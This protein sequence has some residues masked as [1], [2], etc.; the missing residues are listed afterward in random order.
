MYTHT[1]AAKLASLIMYAYDMNEKY[2]NN[3]T[4]PADP[5]IKEDGWNLIAYISGDDTSFSVEKKMLFTLPQSICYGYIAEKKNAPGEYVIIFRGTD[6]TNL[7]EDLHNIIAIF[8]SPWSSAP[9]R[10]VSRGF[11][12]VYDSLKLIAFNSEC[13][14]SQL[15]LANAITQIIGINGQFTILAHSL[16]AAI[17]SYLMCDIAFLAPN[18]S[19]CLFACPRPGNNE[20]VEY[21]DNNFS[22]Y[23]VFNY[24][25]DIVPNLPPDLPVLNISQQWDYEYKSLPNIT[26]LNPP[27][28][29]NIADSIGCNHYL[30]SYIA[31]LDPDEF[32]RVT[33][34]NDAVQG[35]VNSHC[36]HTNK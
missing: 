25:K 12:S 31:I 6:D 34:D 9:E 36:V 11:Y 16:G 23:E 8:T 2:Y 30:T 3:P 22:H 13:D 29:L 35:E 15:K 20:F 26:L 33:T 14:Y 4:P 27:E 5:R 17:A 1:E 18:H 7:L 10:K 24:A 28:A 32:T 21:V 19:A